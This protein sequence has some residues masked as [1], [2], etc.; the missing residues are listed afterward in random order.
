MLGPKHPRG[1]PTDRSESD[2]KTS[3]PQPPQSFYDTMDANGEPGSSSANRGGSQCSSEA[4]THI[5]FPKIKEEIEIDSYSSDDDLE[6]NR[7][8]NSGTSL[9]I[10]FPKM[11]EELTV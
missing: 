11:I 7:L 3:V 1:C 8:G 4:W 5:T 9:P 10:I 2:M 6:I